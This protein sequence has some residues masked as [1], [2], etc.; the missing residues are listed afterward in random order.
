MVTLP[1]DTGVNNMARILKDG[2]NTLGRIA[3]RSL[4]KTM[5]CTKKPRNVRIVMTVEK[6]SK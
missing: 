6:G 3:P 1:S 5:A 2:A 4:E